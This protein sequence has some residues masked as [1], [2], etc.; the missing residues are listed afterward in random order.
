MT[1]P[2]I[3]DITDLT[4]AQLDALPATA[5]APRELRRKLTSLRWLD[6]AQYAARVAAVIR[7]AVRAGTDEDILAVISAALPP[8]RRCGRY[9][10]HFHGGAG[11]FPRPHP[12]VPARLSD[13][14]LRVISDESRALGSLA[15]PLDVL[16]V[17]VAAVC[18]RDFAWGGPAKLLAEIR[19]ALSRLRAILVED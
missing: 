4:A 15:Y 16:A 18:D 10:R 11:T 12:D 9:P 14:Q 7:D 6:R 1:T 19:S 8:D 2:T 13:D 5:R 3:I 17:R